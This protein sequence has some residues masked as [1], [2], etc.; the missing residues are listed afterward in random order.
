MLHVWPTKAWLDVWCWDVCRS[1]FQAVAWVFEFVPSVFDGISPR[2]LVPVMCTLV[3][4]LLLCCQLLLRSSW[5]VLSRSLLDLTVSLCCS[6]LLVFFRIPSGIVVSTLTGIACDAFCL[7][8]VLPYTCL[9]LRQLL[10][11]LVLSLFLWW[12]CS[13]WCRLES[14]VFC[15]VALGGC[16][17]CPCL[18]HTRDT[19]FCTVGVWAHVPFFLVLL[20]VLVL[21]FL[22]LF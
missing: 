12:T 19:N 15:C 5:G 20:V 11:V 7:Q 16:L 8:F 9:F 4:L 17:L 2:C 13:K 22:L 21:V 18:V 3:L 10:S 1:C 6:V 14:L